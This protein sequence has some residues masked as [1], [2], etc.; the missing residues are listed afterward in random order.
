MALFL[1]RLFRVL[2][3]DALYCLL[4]TI[5]FAAK[6][7]LSDSPLS[8]V[9]TLLVFAFCGIFL[10]QLSRWG[11]GGIEFFFTLLPAI[12]LALAPYLAPLLAL[13]PTPFSLVPAVLLSAQTNLLRTCWALAGGFVCWQKVAIRVS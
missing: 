1:K 6:T 13:I 7:L 4:P 8:D 2:M 9:I 11:N 3:W 5:G 12:Y 10:S